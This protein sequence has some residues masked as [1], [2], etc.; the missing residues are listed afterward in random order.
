[1]SE[2]TGAEMIAAERARQVD[3]EGYLPE[4][5]DQHAGNELAWAATCYAAP[6]TVVRVAVQRDSHGVSGAV[7]WDEPWPTEYV[8][9]YIRGNPGRM[10]WRRPQVDRVT[11][12][13]KAGALIA[14]EIDRLKRAGA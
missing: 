13:V 8:E 6:D 4:H 11:E 2:M 9:N 5:D 14:A 10:P 1:M 7:G 12:L 3:S